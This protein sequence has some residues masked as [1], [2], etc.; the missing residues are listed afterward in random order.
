MRYLLP[1]ALAALMACSAG[2]GSRIR[3]TGFLENYTHWNAINKRNIKLGLEPQAPGFAYTP[4]AKVS[5]DIPPPPVAVPTDGSVKPILFIVAP[6]KW[7]A[8]HLGSDDPK[9]EGEILFTVRERFYRYLLRSYPHPVRVR[10]AIRTDDPLLARHRVIVVS[11]RVTD[12]KKGSGTLRYLFGYGMGKARLQ[13]EGQIFEGLEEKKKIGEFAFRVAHQG[14]AQS[15]FNTDVL[16]DD[17]CLKYA[18]EE[19]ILKL[20]HDMPKVLPAFQL[21]ASPAA[22]VANSKGSASN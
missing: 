11:P 16:D 19:G 7:D 13:V 12:F 5:A 14:Y 4:P 18:A 20:T 9:D 1:I 17:Y 22:A 2:C 21:V 8:K 6:A 15:G 3:N 10:Y